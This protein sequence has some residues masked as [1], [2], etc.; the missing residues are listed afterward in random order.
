MSNR[1]RAK[2]KEII[3]IKEHATVE[4]VLTDTGTKRTP[5][6]S[7][8]ILFSPKVPFFSKV[9]LYQEDT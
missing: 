9:N 3:S 1:V 7:G 8:H 6:L 4:P 2:M 5:V